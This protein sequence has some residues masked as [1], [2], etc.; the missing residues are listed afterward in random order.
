M[1]KRIL[2]VDDEPD[3]RDVVRIILEAEGFEIEE[4][5]DGKEA[6][7]RIKRRPPDLIIIDYVMPGLDGASVCA[8]VKKDI[9]LRHL[10][11]IMLTGKGDLTDKIKG[12][13]AGA[14]D[15]IVKPFEPQELVA[16]VKM[17]LR[18][19]EIDLD[20]NPLTKLPGNVSI[21]N[22]IENRIL[23]N[24]HFAVCYL[25]IDKF[26][27]Y[28]DR[29]GFEKGDYVIQETARILVEVLHEKGN[30]NDFIGHVGGDDFVIITTPEKVDVICSQIIKKFDSKAPQ[31][32]EKADRERGYIISKDRQGR[33]LQIPIMS[34]SIAVVTNKTKQLTHVAEVAQLGA[35]IK[36]YLKTLPGSNYCIDR[37]E[38]S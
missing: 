1:A 25:D 30:Q 18:R 31:F 34:V 10:P 7:Q 38:E 37:R 17:V 12:I 27:S 8:E 26:K 20:A 9:L 13:D 24:E 2:V 29:Y 4:A 11:I 33:N 36:E 22:E 14:D 15:Y 19:S 3:V 21:L 35:E 23:K 32:Y 6:L 28:N 16:R 5:G